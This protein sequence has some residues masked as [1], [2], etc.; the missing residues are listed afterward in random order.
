MMNLNPFLLLVG[1]I[2]QRGGAIGARPQ[3]GARVAEL[4]TVKPLKP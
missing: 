1:T 3:L 2:V 4:G